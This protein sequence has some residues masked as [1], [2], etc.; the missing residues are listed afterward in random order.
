MNVYTIQTEIVLSVACDA[1]SSLLNDSWS[2]CLAI[3]YE[4]K[5]RR[6]LVLNVPQKKQQLGHG[7]RRPE[8]SET[9][10]YFRTTE[11]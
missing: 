9:R 3:A 4:V 10:Y 1:E 6:D 7:R 2:S 11:E 8:G 5:E